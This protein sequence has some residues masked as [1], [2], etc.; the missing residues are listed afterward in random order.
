[1][2]PHQTRSPL[3]DTLFPYATLFRSTGRSAPRGWGPRDAPA[4][5]RPE[6]SRR[7]AALPGRA[8][9]PAPAMAATPPALVPTFRPRTADRRTPGRPARLAARTEERRIGKECGNI[10]NHRW[11][12]YPLKKVYHQMTKISHTTNNIE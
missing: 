7:P 11:S 2:I 6:R 4:T 1:M 3:T 8:T 9:H 5:P 10:G 12:L